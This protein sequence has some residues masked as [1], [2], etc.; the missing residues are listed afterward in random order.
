MFSKTRRLQSPTG[1][2]LACRHAPARGKAKGVVLISH[3]LA[4]HS[5]RYAAFAERLAQEGFH[6]HAHDHR[7]HGETTAPDAPL[8]R[9]A[10][11]AGHHLAIA[12]ML[13]VRQLAAATHPGLPVIQFGHSMGGLLALSFAQ[14]NPDKVDALAVW[15]ANLNPGLAGRAAQVI[16]LAE[17]MLKGSDVP[18]GPIPRLTF[19][20]WAKAVADRG[21]D[22]DW[23]SHDPAEVEKY[24]RDPLCGFDASVSLWLDVFAIAFAAA[25]ARQIARMPRAL[26]IQLVGG[27]EDPATD[28]GRA[29]TWLARRLGSKGLA[30]VTA[31]VYRGLRH[32]TLLE[33]QHLREK[34]IEEF[35]DWIG[36]VVRNKR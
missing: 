20:A 22:F 32:E 31:V 11:R 26:P 30:D 33:Q 3:G 18:S 36:R 8:G 23:L 27:D 35:C 21:T 12:D 19:G 10:T 25:S 16:L 7:G 6:V 24:M 5:G 29:V 14:A 2:E 13:A 1:A 15:N 17:R 34:P 9:F 28:F 4:E